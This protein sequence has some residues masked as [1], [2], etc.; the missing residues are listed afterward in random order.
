[1]AN[2]CEEAQFLLGLGAWLEVPGFVEASVAWVP[3]MMSMAFSV[4]D[5]SVA[6]APSSFSYVQ[7]HHAHI[8]I[9]AP[10]RWITGASEEIVQQYAAVPDPSTGGRVSYAW[11]NTAV[12]LATLSEGWCGSSVSTCHFCHVGSHGLVEYVCHIWEILAIPFQRYDTTICGHFALFLSSVFLNMA[13][14]A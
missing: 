1:M 14:C 3:A 9:H 2:A 4:S 12:Y 11:L 6:L 10:W 13:D 5:S 8:Q 7:N